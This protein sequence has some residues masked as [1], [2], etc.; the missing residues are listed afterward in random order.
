MSYLLEARNLLNYRYPK[1]ID[2]VTG[3]GYTIGEGSLIG[4]LSEY[5][6]ARYSDPSFWST[7]RSVRVGVSTEF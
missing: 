4:D 7:P 5:E 1:R 3:D 6:A 2:A